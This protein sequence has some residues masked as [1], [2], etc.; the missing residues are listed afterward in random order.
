MSVD[1]TNENSM[2]HMWRNLDE[3]QSV[4]SAAKSSK[5]GVLEHGSEAVWKLFES[6]VLA[7]LRIVE[8]FLA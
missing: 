8:K 1:I 6:N 7:Q 4:L 3:S 2:R 5:S